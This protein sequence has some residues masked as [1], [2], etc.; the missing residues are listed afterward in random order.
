MQLT[1]NCFQYLQDVN[2]KRNDCESKECFT[3]KLVGIFSIQ[4]FIYFLKY[5]MVLIAHKMIARE[6]VLPRNL[7]RFVNRIFRRIFGISFGYFSFQKDIWCDLSTGLLEG[8]LLF[9]LD[10]YYRLSRRIFV[11]VIICLFRRIFGIV[12][13]E[14]YLL[15]LLLF[16]RR[17]FG[18]IC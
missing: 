5:F 9:L 12:F 16:F 18:E 8:Y 13:L 3:E 7:V 10:I 6:N 1:G 11:I 15:S 2:C 17:I 4:I 14:G